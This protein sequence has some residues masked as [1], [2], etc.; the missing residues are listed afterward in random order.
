MS[1]V[2]RDERYPVYTPNEHCPPELVA[3]YR[4]AEKAFQKAQE[5]LRGLWE[6]DNPPAAP[7]EICECGGTVEPSMCEIMYCAKCGKGRFK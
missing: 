2:T 1:R 5:K 6:E 7:Q 3:E 4:R